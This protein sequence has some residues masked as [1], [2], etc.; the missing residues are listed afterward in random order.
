MLKYLV[1]LLLTC[2]SFLDACD[3]R[4]SFWGASAEHRENLQALI[5]GHKMMFPA[6]DIAPGALDVQLGMVWAAVLLLPK[7]QATAHPS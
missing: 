4:A 7:G 2:T 1:L 6:T 3:L 5:F